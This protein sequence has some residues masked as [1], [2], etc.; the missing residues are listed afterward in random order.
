MDIRTLKRLEFDKVLRKLAGQ[1]TSPLGKELALALSPET[2]VST[3]LAWQAETTEGRELLRLEPMAEV[4]GWHDVRGAVQRAERQAVLAAEE[5]L[6]VGE[7]LAVSRRIKRFFSERSDRY[8]I[9]ADLATVF[10]SEPVLE[11]DIL[12]AILPGGEIADQ[13]SAELAQIRR[14]LLREQGRVRERLEHIIRSPGTQKY[15]QDPII[16]IRGDRYVVPVKQ[17]FRG[18]LPGIVHDQ[19]ASGAT[20]F[21]EPMAVVE[22]NNTLRRLVAAEKQEILRILSTLSGQVSTIAQEIRDGLAALGQLDFIMA[23][24]RY[25]QTLKAWSPKRLDGSKLQIINGR[26]PLLPADA[27]PATLHLGQNFATL[28]ITGPNTGGKTVT[29]KTVGL[30][31]LMY[32]S[33]LHIPADTNSAMGVFEQVFADIGDEQSIEQSLSTFSSHMTNLV[34]IIGQAGPDSL[35]LLDELGAGTDP[36]EGAALAQA[37]LEKLHG[38]GAKTIATTHYSELKNFAYNTSGVEN[39]SVEFNAETLR[40]TYKLLIGRPGRSNAFEIS[41][42]L[43]LSEKITD[44]ARSFLTTEQIQVADMI[45]HL[46]QTQKA[47]ERERQ[48][49]ERLR[50]EA[51]ALKERYHKLEQDLRHKKETIVT[52]AHTEAQDLVRAARLEAEDT[53]KELRSKISA[54]NARGREEAIRTAREKL[55]KTTEKVHKKKPEPVS[56]GEIPRSVRPGEAVF[57]PQYNQKGHVLAMSDS[58]MVQV[59]V[60]IMRL[61]VPIKELRQVKEEKVQLGQVK[62]GKVMADKAKSISTSLDLRGMTADEAL[63][64]MEKYLDDV[65][66]AGLPRVNLIHGKG[67]GALRAAIQRELAGHHRVKSFRPGEMGEGGMGVTIVDIK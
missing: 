25:S 35:V 48:E 45:L 40:P 10:V 13:A 43:G 24:A 31:V 54:E 57:L 62:V 1:T 67:T 63:I 58:D 18:Q 42:R 8:K 11:K 60:G 33:G 14:S 12:N 26:H 46:E 30:L 16:T 44:R 9:L 4:A 22:A 55:Q 52:Q 37:I 23:K 38:S 32:Q 59:Q 47:A 21:V 53:I 39:A 19:S 17:E 50:A 6:A 51:A 5:L 66:L 28:I 27:V 65:F 41:T 7:T 61:T 36:T 15:L 34:G 64:E 3:I 56:E 29:L 20:L 49:T 2:D